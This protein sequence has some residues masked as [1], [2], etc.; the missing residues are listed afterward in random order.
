L[1]LQ[2]NKLN[3][4]PLLFAAVFFFVFIERSDKPIRNS[5][6]IAT[7]YAIFHA[8]LIGRLLPSLA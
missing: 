1:R 6:Y 8:T 3:F 5:C 4:K 7:L 2:N